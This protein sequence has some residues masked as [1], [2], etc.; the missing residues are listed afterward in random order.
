MEE[1]QHV[2]A[3]SWSINVTD[4]SSVTMQ[5]AFYL[6]FLCFNNVIVLASYIFDAVAGL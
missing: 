5:P 4:N 2:L 6:K 3:A 1:M